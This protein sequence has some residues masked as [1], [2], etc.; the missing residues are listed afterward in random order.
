MAVKLMLP[1]VRCAFLVLG[2]PD[3]YQDNKRFRWS[4]T[5]LIPNGSDLLKKVQAAMLETAVEKWGKKGQAIYEA[6][7]SDKQTTCLLDGKKKPEYDGYEGHHALTAHRP[8]D[9]GRPLVYTAKK[10]PIY[11]PSNELYEGMAGKMYSGCFVNMQVQFWAQDNKNG[12]A[13][14]TELLGVQFVKD[15]PAFGGGAKPNEE[16]FA[17]IEDGA[18][19]DDLS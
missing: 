8:Q 18:D 5:G 1:N 11:K 14:R 10:E 6:V 2:E 17:E 15:G 4:A 7:I 9:K 3:D 19:A 16:D 13:L 12:K